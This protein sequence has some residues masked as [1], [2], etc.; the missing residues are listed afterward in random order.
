[1]RIGEFQNKMQGETLD[2]E[3]IH[4]EVSFGEAVKYVTGNELEYAHLECSF[5]SMIVYLNDA[6]M[7]NEEAEIHAE[8]SFGSTVLYVPADWRVI[9]NVSSAFGGVEEKGN[10]NPEGINTLYIRGNVSFGSLEIR[11]L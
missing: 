9:L 8:C 3:N 7:K 4:F 5:G 11:Y 10:C 2:G 6:V 1:M